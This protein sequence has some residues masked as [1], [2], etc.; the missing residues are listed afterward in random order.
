[1]IIDPALLFDRFRSPIPFSTV[2]LLKD[3]PALTAFA[4]TVIVI[5]L[6][7]SR[8]PSR[9]TKPSRVESHSPSSVSTARI[10]KLYEISSSSECSAGAITFVA[11]SDF[12]FMSTA[13]WQF[14]F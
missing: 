6:L 4:E 11:F 12:W 13:T 3:F 8:T 10:F 2:T 7:T 5:E 14:N 9:Q 1:V